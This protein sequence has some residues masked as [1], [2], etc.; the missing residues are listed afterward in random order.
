MSDAS[1]AEDNTGTE[2]PGEAEA[3]ARDMGWKPKEDWVGDDSGWVDADKFIE[4]QESRAQ[5]AALTENKELKEQVAALRT[6]QAETR[7]TL[8]EFKEHR[9]KTEQRMYDRAMKD[10]QAEQR[11][12]VEAGDTEAFDKAAQDQDALLK[13]AAKPDAKPKAPDADDIPAYKDWVAKNPWYKTDLRLR[14]EANALAME[15]PQV[16]GLTPDMPAFYEKITETL[17]AEFPDKFENQNRKKPAAVEES[18]GAPNRSKKGQGYDSLPVEAKEACDRYIK[19]GLYV[20]E[21]GKAMT[22]AKAR[23]QYCADYYEKDE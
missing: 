1:Q 14:R 4:K 22:T 6:E 2:I 18:A 5:A 23:E 19:E 11:K 16:H 3:K 17:K 10:I 13:D 8:D 15:I 21:A 9:S 7:R 20:D 12:A